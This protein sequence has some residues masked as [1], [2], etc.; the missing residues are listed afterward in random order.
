MGKLKLEKSYLDSTS[1]LVAHLQR[2]IGKSAVNISFDRIGGFL[3]DNILKIAMNE[4]Q[5]TE[6]EKT[7]D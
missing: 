1:E 2:S 4:N 7:E 5:S 6:W 3:L